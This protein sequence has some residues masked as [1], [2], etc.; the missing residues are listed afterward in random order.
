MNPDE[1]RYPLRCQ[2]RE[3][4][5]QALDVQV[6]RSEFGNLHV[7]HRAERNS[8]HDPE[9]LAV[10]P[11]QQAGRHLGR[12]LVGAQRVDGCKREWDQKEE[13]TDVGHVENLAVS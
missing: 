12:D 3:L 9:R 4:G 13:G 11:G 10:G 7:P 1:R 8:D 6:A 2:A 5:G